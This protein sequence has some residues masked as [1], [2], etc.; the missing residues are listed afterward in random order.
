M[1]ESEIASDVS[2]PA[3]VVRVPFWPVSLQV[4]TFY[5]ENHHDPV[6]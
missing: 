6:K 2:P 1:L 3:A 5:I 4:Q